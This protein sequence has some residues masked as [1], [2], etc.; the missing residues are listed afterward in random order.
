MHKLRAMIQRIASPML[1]LPPPQ[2]RTPQILPE[3]VRTPAGLFPRAAPMPTKGLL[4]DR[5]A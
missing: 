1:C 4:I 2:R 3:A 5:L